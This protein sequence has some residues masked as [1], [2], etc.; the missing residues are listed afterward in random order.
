[1]I[2]EAGDATILM[3][4]HSL[5]ETITLQAR[6]ES[7]EHGGQVTPGEVLNKALRMYLE[8]HGKKEAVDYLFA[9]SGGR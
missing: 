5:V 4:P 6:G 7:R 8:E 1:M 9:I 2:R 3:V